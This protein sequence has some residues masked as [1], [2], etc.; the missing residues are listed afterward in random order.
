MLAM[1]IDRRREQAP[2]LPFEGLLLAVG[3]PNRR[4]AT[5]TDYIN[6]CLK[7]VPLLFA[8]DR[9]EFHRY[10]RRWFPLCGSSSDK[11]RAC[12]SDPK[13]PAPSSLYPDKKLPYDGDAFV[14]YPLLI[15]GPTGVIGF[16]VGNHKYLLICLALSLLHFLC[17]YSCAGNFVQDSAKT[18]VLYLQL[19]SWAR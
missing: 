11:R 10:R 17:T 13:V 18:F 16:L 8:F 6:H 12:P 5:T 19:A 2:R 4:R 1:A 15:G 9:E 3:L 14:L 7:E